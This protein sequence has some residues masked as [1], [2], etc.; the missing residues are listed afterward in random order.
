MKKKGSHMD[1]PKIE[2]YEF[3]RIVIDGQP[4]QAD[5]ILLPE[6]ILDGWWRKEGHLL[7]SADLEAVLDAA[8]DLL[9]VGQGAYGRMKIAGEAKRAIEQAGIQ[10]VA[11]RTGE[12]VK[13]FNALSDDR[14]VALA[15]HLTC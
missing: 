8:P 13:R 9:I 3:G 5:L 15:L 1:R 12:A 14:T 4:Y 10:M 11:S 2:S 6:R 7:Q